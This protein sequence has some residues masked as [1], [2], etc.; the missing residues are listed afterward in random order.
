MVK[1]RN[2]GARGR[3][4]QSVKSA[5]V[6]GIIQDNS[7]RIEDRLTDENF[8][9]IMR[10]AGVTSKDPHSRKMR[11][12]RLAVI[13][14][15]LQ[16]SPQ[17]MQNVSFSKMKSELKN[18]EKT[19]QKFHT[20][21]SELSPETMALLLNCDDMV[22]EEIRNGSAD[23]GNSMFGHPIHRL[24][25]DDE[26]PAVW[27]PTIQNISYY[28]TV[29]FNMVSWTITNMKPRDKGGRNSNILVHD[30]VD[31]LRRVWTCELGQP[32]TLDAHK[33]EPIS[34]AAHFCSA[35]FAAVDSNVTFQEIET[36]MRRTIRERRDRGSET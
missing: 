11:L 1:S 35:F 22:S 8:D 31:M 13:Y 9:A 16:Q 28:V 32:F 26:N 19:I 6:F 20:A 25:P 29:L 27:F 24:N 17:E 18:L 15:A 21:M 36:A 10:A 12:A 30:T 14:D 2:Q 33:G 3:R 34:K 5:D 7:D 4:A 23:I